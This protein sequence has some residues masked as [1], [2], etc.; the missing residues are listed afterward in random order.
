MSLIALQHP[1]QDELKSFLDSIASENKSS[2]TR[3]A[4]Q[5]DLEQFFETKIITQDQ[6]KSITMEDVETYRNDLISQGRKSTTVNRKLTS[7]RKFFKRLIAKGIVDVN[8]ADTAVVKSMKVEPS[9]MGKSISREDIEKMIECSLENK[10]RLKSARDYAMLLIMVYCGLRR[11]EVANMR[12]IDLIVEDGYNVLRLPKTKSQVEQFVKIPKRGYNALR[13]LELAYS[14]FYDVPTIDGYIFTSMSKHQNF[15]RQLSVNSIRR[16]VM[17]YGKQIGISIT[18]HMFR[19]SCCTLAIEGGAKPHQ[20][21][22]HLRHKDIKTT[23]LY[24][25]A[26][27][28]LTDN[29]SDYI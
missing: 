23:M 4:Y 5:T 1:I 25:D 6:V 10:N 26:K 27:D 21:Q 8:P 20:V 12:W 13:N 22:A 11:A 15:G 9:V 7:L 2:S 24:Y 14:N 17:G 18:P 16:I 19:H 29:A 28:K 3:T